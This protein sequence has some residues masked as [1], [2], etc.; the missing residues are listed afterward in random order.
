MS[1]IMGISGIISS[2][3]YESNKYLLMAKIPRNTDKYSI[4]FAPYASFTLRF[5]N[6]KTK[7]ST[8]A[9]FYSRYDKGLTALY[10]GNPLIKLA[11][12]N[13][14]D[15][16]LVYILPTSADG[17]FYTM[18]VE[19]AVCDSFIIPV[20]DQIPSKKESDMESTSYIS[21]DPNGNDEIDLNFLFDINAS[22]YAIDWMQRTTGVKH[23]HCYINANASIVETKGELLPTRNIGVWFVKT[24]LAPSKSWGVGTQKWEFVSEYKH[25]IYERYINENSWTQ[26]RLILDNTIN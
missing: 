10:K 22:A 16:F 26:F 20:C 6:S 4:A 19:E 14:D 11:I 2:D 8:E 12:E 3:V 25:V 15:F 17:A 21:L 23:Y 18:V 9:A 24:D 13:T 5:T 1:K 7:E